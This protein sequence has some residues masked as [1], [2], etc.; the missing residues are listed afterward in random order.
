MINIQLSTINFRINY[1]VI[2]TAKILNRASNS[3][4]LSFPHQI[5][6]YSLCITFCSHRILFGYCTTRTTFQRATFCKS[7]L[8]HDLR[9]NSSNG[10]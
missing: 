9:T 1:L 10:F 7:N 3:Q 2:F 4:E 6:S 8:L 5:Q